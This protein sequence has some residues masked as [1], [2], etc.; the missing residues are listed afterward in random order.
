MRLHCC[1]P[2]ENPNRL[3]PVSRWPP[4][5]GQQRPMLTVFGQQRPTLTVFG[6]QRPTLTVFGQQR[7]MLTVF[8]APRPQEDH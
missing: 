3:S 6:Q 2:A 5:A 7:P 1:P 8:A 4:S